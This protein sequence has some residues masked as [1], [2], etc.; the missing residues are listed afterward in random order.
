MVV[1]SNRALLLSD[2]DPDRQLTALHPSY[3]NLQEPT[4][5]P[6]LLIQQITHFFQHYYDLEERRQYSPLQLPPPYPRCK[7]VRPVITALLTLCITALPVHA[8][9][10]FSEPEMINI[11]NTITNHRLTVLQDRTPIS[12]CAIDEFWDDKGAL[13]VRDY[14]VGL[15]KYKNRNECPKGNAVTPDSTGSTVELT[16]IA[17]YA[18][19][20]V[21]T[22]KTT[23]GS[24]SFTERYFIG[25]G[26]AGVLGEPAYSAQLVPVRN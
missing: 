13:L 23:R 15:S 19:S 4:D 24:R 22:G 26:A 18:D 6:S 14:A 2:L 11:S 12:Y 5:H 1:H 8:Q 20:V 16:S 25:W 3:T 9:H 7:P 21:I 10:R 17:I